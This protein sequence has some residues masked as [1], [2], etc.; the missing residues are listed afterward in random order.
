M[1]IAIGPFKVIKVIFVCASRSYETNVKKI[2]HP[3]EVHNKLYKVIK[4]HIFRVRS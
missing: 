4:S 3:Y 2:S 1:G